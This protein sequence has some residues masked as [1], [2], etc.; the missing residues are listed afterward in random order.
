MIQRAMTQY[1]DGIR[2]PNAT[3]RWSY[4]ESLGLKASP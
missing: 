4:L 1:L 3:I 2:L